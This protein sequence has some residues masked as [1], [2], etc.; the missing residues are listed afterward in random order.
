[1]T[2]EIGLKLKCM[3]DVPLCNHTA[4]KPM[5][6]KVTRQD[7]RIGQT[8]SILS[9]GHISVL[10]LNVFISGES[11]RCQDAIHARRQVGIVSILDI[12]IG[13]I[14]LSTCG[15]ALFYQ[16]CHISVISVL[17][18]T[19]GSPERDIYLRRLTPFSHKSD[20]RDN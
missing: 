8:H 13:L 6:W 14:G 11:S 10:H 3:F 20:M 15:I 16:L 18:I 19:R 9:Y 7:R 2:T 17:T 1:M 12:K 5:I 4:C